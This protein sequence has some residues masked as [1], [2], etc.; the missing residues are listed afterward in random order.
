MQFRFVVLRVIPSRAFHLVYKALF[1]FLDPPLSFSPYETED[2]WLFIFIFVC[3]LN[4][5]DASSLSPVVPYDGLVSLHSSNG[6]DN[7]IVNDSCQWNPPAEN[8]SSLDAEALAMGI[9][10]IVNYIDIRIKC[11]VPLFV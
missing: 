9:H 5:I 7:D 3:V 8:D 1:P 6:H 4:F 11:T 10:V 2:V